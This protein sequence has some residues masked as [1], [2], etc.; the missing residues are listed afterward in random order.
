LQLW[1]D[2][3]P[4]AMSDEESD[5]DSI[6][7]LRTLHWRKHEV[8]VLIQRC[9]TALGVIRNYGEP[10]EKKPDSRC[11][12]FVNPDYVPLDNTQHE[13]LF[14]TRHFVIITCHVKSERVWPLQRSVHVLTMFQSL[15]YNITDTKHLIILK[16]NNNNN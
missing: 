11:K 1:Q 3:N 12:K 14:L 16:K 7:V 8:S 5:E 9:D 4:W 10:S 2:L 15:E 13:L 6:R